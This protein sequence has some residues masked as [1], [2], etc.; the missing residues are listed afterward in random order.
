MMCR[1]V[2][3]TCRW[4]SPFFLLAEFCP[5][6][7]K[8]RATVRFRQRSTNVQ[9]VRKKVISLKHVKLPVETSAA[10]HTPTD[11]HYENSC[12]GHG[13]GKFCFEYC[14]QRLSLLIIP[15]VPVLS[16]IANIRRNI[17]QVQAVFRPINLKKIYLNV[18][19][20]C[21]NVN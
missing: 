2:P 13:S 9:P 4:G 14:D 15:A 5:C 12:T 17:R 10:E 7:S 1:H 20:D 21:H 6:S 18:T 19:F 16:Y 8:D 11:N 3:V